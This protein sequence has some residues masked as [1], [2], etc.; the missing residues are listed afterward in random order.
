TVSAPGTYTVTVTDPTNGCTSTATTVVDQNITKPGANA[1]GGTLTCVVLSIQL[2]AS[3]STGGVTYSWK[4]PG[5][6]ASGQQNPTV[7][8]TGTYTVT[9]TNPVN[10]CTSTATAVVDQNITKPGAN[11][12]GGTLTCVVLSVQLKGSSSTG[13]VTY[14]WSGPGGY[15]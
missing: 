10:G 13:G 2:N 8:V 5:G 11:A 1:S 6:Y 4:G 7:G 9:V 15:T 3:S 14:S 12:T